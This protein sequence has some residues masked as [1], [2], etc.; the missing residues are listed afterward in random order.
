[1]GLARPGSIAAAVEQ[2]SSK[3]R[4]AGVENGGADAR[5]L[6]A[7]SLGVVPTWIFAHALEPLTD[8]GRGIFDDLVARR[9]SRVPLQHLLG[10]TEFWSLR[11][12]VGP[13]VLVP[14]PETE[15]LVEAALEALRG[16]Q[17]VRLADV[18][19]GSGCV[20]VALARELALARLVAI[21]LCP[22]ALAVARRNAEELGFED[23]IDFREGDLVAPLRG[24]E[25]LD[26]VVANLPYVSESEWEDC[27]PEVR[28][29]DPRLAL[30]AGE[31][32]L[33]LIDRLI[34][35]APAVL[36]EGGWLGLE[37][38]WTQA[39]QVS[40]LLAERGWSAIAVRKDFAGID[41]VVEA[42]RPATV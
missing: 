33:E 31:E 18:G 5:L 16:Q 40:T 34:L 23:R 28:D 22:A 10:E 19:T 24:D 36:G 20:A 1:M 7:K 26:A 39:G 17:R 8:E 4:A 15:L 29:H 9:A 21:D 11:F 25:P 30:V 41:R 37:V 6:L 32:G 12:A 42:R 27:E 2:A 14:R 35:E 38:G 3:L 13:E